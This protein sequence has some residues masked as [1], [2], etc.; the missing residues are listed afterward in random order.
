M[1]RRRLALVALILLIVAIAVAARATGLT[2]Y[3]RPENLGVLRQWISSLGPAGPIVFILGYAVATVAF[4]P[5]TP[6]T[7]LG[8]ILFGA[9]LGA[10][11]AALGATIGLTLAF[12]LARYAARDLVA[13]R[14]QRNERLRRL[15]EG[16]ERQGWR[17][18]VLTRLVPVFPFN[19]QNY[20]YGL[21]RIGLATYALVSGICILPGVAVYAFAGGSLGTLSAGGDLSRVFVYLGLAAVIFVAL[22]LLPGFIRRRYSSPELDENRDDSSED[23]R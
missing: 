14:V 15:D 2:E 11:Y 4:L 3:L 17:I 21:T 19:L 6:L 8:G 23:P 7:L 12:L 9:L 1:S 18:L 22:S 16:V 5:G 20:A 10:V 13:S